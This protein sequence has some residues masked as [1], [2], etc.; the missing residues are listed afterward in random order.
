MLARLTGE[1]KLLVFWAG[2]PLVPC[3]GCRRQVCTEAEAGV[4]E[5]GTE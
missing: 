4:A 3:D 2:D 1:I 5:T